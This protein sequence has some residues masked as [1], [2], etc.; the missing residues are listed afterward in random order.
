[1][2]SIDQTDEPL[3]LWNT[4]QQRRPRAESLHLVSVR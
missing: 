4:A 1:V 3:V 2:S